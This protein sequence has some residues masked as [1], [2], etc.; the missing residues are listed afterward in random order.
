VRDLGEHLADFEQGF[1]GWFGGPRDGGMLQTATTG[2]PL[3]EF[4]KSD[5]DL[6][7][8]PPL[9]FS[10]LNPVFDAAIRNG[11]VRFSSNS[12]GA[13]PPQPVPSWVMR[14]AAR[15]LRDRGYPAE[16]IWC[17]NRDEEPATNYPAM[18]QE[19][20]WLRNNGFRPFSSFHNL[21]AVPEHLAILNPVFDMFQGGYTTAADRADRR[22]EGK[23]DAT[24]EVWMYQGWGATWFT[25]QANRQPG[26]L[27]A[28]TELDGYHVHVY[29]RWQRLDAIIFPTE[30]GP[31]GSPA[32]EGMRDGMADAQ[33]VA[34]A[35]RWIERVE[36]A[37][38]AD[39]SLQPIAEGA[40][41]KLLRI[42][43]GEGGSLVPL[44]RKRDRLVWVERV[45]TLA[46]PALEKARTAVLDLLADLRPHVAKLGPSL[47]YGGHVL[48]ENGR[49]MTCLA[50]AAHASGAT[51]V[52]QL[53]KDRFGVQVRAADSSGT[54]FT[55]DLQTRQV[56]GSW[57]ADPP[58]VTDSYP[59]A[60]EYVIHLVPGG[61]AKPTRLLIFGRDDAGLEKGIRQWLCFLRT[62]RRGG[63]RPG[64]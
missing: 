47:Y 56:P 12:G 30:Q 17:K 37:A 42:V 63:S 38:A 32:W 40:R 46:M 4:L 55:L 26:W 57:K 62:E 52:A 33:Y 31:E 41:Q 58:H 24:D 45:P 27:T 20:Q 7:S 39:A 36:R 13:L 48:A 49:V 35:R 18:A 16:D 54:S 10:Y 51:L 34:L 3:Q 25:Y 61:E 50:P 8:P 23:L 6:A 53:L 64:P 11:L 21:L 22:K 2:Q 15:Y 44:E 5:P 28:A 60:G 9:D 59:P 19:V 14:E 43:G 1:W 29:Y